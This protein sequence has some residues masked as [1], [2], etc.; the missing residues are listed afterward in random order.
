MFAIV[1]VPL[2]LSHA[3]CSHS[4]CVN[5]LIR[6][7]F[8]VSEKVLGTGL[9]SPVFLLDQFDIGLF[10]FWE[11]GWGWLVGH[12]NGLCQ[13]RWLHVRPELAVRWRVWGF[14]KASFL[15]SFIKAN[16]NCLIIRPY[17]MRRLLRGWRQ[18]C[19]VRRLSVYIFFIIFDW[20]N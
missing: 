14:E 16:T 6:R 19:T 3:L 8:Q 20:C 11:H 5:R 10:V 4:H 2:C 12:V 13:T 7:F 15:A 17:A 1:A 18:Q 9:G